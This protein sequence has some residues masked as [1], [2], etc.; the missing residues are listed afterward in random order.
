M[1]AFGSPHGLLV[2]DIDGLR[3]DVFHQALVEH[4]IP[5][6]ARLLGGAEKNYGFHLDPVSS[7][8]SITFCAQSTIFTGQNPAA[9]GIPGNQFFDRFGRNTGGV[10][11]FYAFDVGDALAYDD[12][13]F[14]F[15]GSIGLLGQTLD[16]STLTL[17]EQAAR[18]GLSATVVYHM[19]S[20][21]AAHWIRPSLVDIARF[22]KGG[23][24]IGMSSEQY[25]HEMMEKTLA[26]LRSGA[27]PDILTVYFMGLDHISHQEGP[28]SQLGYL[29]RVVDGEVGRL[30]SELHANGLLS[31]RLIAVVSDHGQIRVIP[32]DRHSLRLSF[33]FDREMGYLFDALGLDVHDKPRE[34]PDTDAVVAANGGMA[35]VYLRRRGEN[36]D[37]APRFSADV[38]P[39]AQ[40]FW[41][42]HQT[43][44]YSQDLLGALSL[45]LV[46]N[47]EQQG[48]YAAYQALTPSGETI[49]VEAYL[50]EHP[51]IRVIEAAARLRTLAGPLSGD[52]LLV[53][54]Y[55]DG[56][57]FG[58]P[59][60]GVHG[61]LHPEDSLAVAS[62][63]WVDASSTQLEGLAE[64][65]R[66][67]CQERQAAENRGHSSL[68]D[69]LPLLARLLSFN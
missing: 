45:L 2:I 16:S 26:H 41:A 36:W 64:V 5:N 69:L 37:A 6:L 61:G 49:P 44:Q 54:N 23:G 56:F 12:A 22:T 24:L 48:W 20:R 35:H 43:G 40:A 66:E 39:V 7:F 31:G 52:L 32:D 19:V 25:D 57:Y 27:R 59:T 1:T 21:G 63:G 13:V 17:Y 53:S 11:R 60:V 29:S 51:E 9:H 8:P 55:A 18:H 67:I 58:A 3:Q 65:A 68:A 46:R 10:P 38:L 34:G 28:E 4:R 33:P 15:T 14:T 47:V 50:N 30:V 62:L 42:A